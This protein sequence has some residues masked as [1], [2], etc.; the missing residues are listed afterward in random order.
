MEPFIILGLL[1]LGAGAVVVSVLRSKTTE[2]GR[3][4]HTLAMRL[5]FD[6]VDVRH[7][8]LV[9]MSGQVQAWDVAIGRVPM[10]KA[11]V[12]PYMLRTV[13]TGP[14]LVEDV[15]FGTET[16]WPVLD[17]TT[18]TIIETGD[19]AFDRR[20][21][22]CG[23]ELMARALLDDETRELVL[24]LVEG[25]NSA[26]MDGELIGDNDKEEAW[27]VLLTD[28]RIRRMVRLAERL[29]APPDGPSKRIAELAVHERNAAVRHRC[30][31]SLSVFDEACAREVAPRVL[32]DESH[33][34]RLVAAEIVGPSARPVLEALL[35][36]LAAP[37][38]V[39]GTALARLSELA[40]REELIMWIQEYADQH[41]PAVARASMRT[42]VQ[43]ELSEVVPTIALLVQ[44]SRPALAVEA[45]A[46]LG[47]LGGTDAQRHVIDALTSDRDRIARAACRT[48]G[49]V[50]TIDAV[51]PLLASSKGM[52]RDPTLKQLA[53]EAVK[54]IQARAEGG[55]GGQLSVVATESDGAVSVAEDA[56]A[57]GIVEEE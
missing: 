15:A 46:S 54:A 48:L 53:R 16:F 2:Q 51:E 17:A 13:V 41:S 36:D 31:L 18:D 6:D 52:L 35:T 39:R 42:A 40:D 44:A 47:E 19:A 3:E 8:Q 24:E 4:W 7:G 49:R 10:G 43:L 14:S 1:S 37:D 56:G 55:S 38:E 27:S 28:R 21:K 11:D 25:G 23:S 32:S 9:R 33:D 12:L 57:L 20:I 30:L 5:G 29:R 45:V 50:G 26:L 22:V 34:V